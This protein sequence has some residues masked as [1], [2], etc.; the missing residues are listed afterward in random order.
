MGSPEFEEYPVLD[1]VVFRYFSG[2]LAMLQENFDKAEEHLAC[3]FRMCPLRAVR[4]RQKILTYLIPVRLMLIAQRS[5]IKRYEWMSGFP[6]T[7]IFV[8]LRLLYNII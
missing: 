2:R 5:T 3:A 4:Q 1:Q 8:F 6:A 7:L